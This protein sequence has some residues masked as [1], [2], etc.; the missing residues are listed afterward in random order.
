MYRWIWSSQ[1]EFLPFESLLRGRY[2]AL[3]ARSL[4]SKGATMHD[5]FGMANVDQTWAKAYDEVSNYRL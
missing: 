4:D 1:A 5:D 2:G 3:G